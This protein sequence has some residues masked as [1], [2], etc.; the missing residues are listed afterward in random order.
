MV[1][2]CPSEGCK[3]LPHPPTPY[4]LLDLPCLHHDLL[5]GAA[6]VGCVLLHGAS[7]PARQ[8]KIRRAA[9]P[10]LGDSHPAVPRL[11]DSHSPPAAAN[12]ELPQARALPELLHLSNNQRW[13]F[14]HIQAE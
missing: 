2:L 11:G 3:G 6:A 13:H 8:A 10:R 5:R 14:R 1:L 7:A 12:Q 4:L 9:V